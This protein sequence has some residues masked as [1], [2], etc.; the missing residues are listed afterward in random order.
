MS[1]IKQIYYQTRNVYNNDGVFETV[2]AE[3]LDIFKN[4]R[5]LLDARLDKEETYK[6]N[7]LGYKVLDSE[8]EPIR[9]LECNHLIEKDGVVVGSVILR[10]SNNFATHGERM[11]GDIMQR[12]YELRFKTFAGCDFTVES[13]GIAAS[14]RDNGPILINS[15]VGTGFADKILEKHWAEFK[16][17]VTFTAAE[18]DKPTKMRTWTKNQII[19]ARA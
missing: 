2:K 18:V 8:C 13:S 9:S 12:T 5:A 7:G 3:F 16:A 11:F 1:D 10:V 15:C 4:M 19:Y 14:Q 6:A 17:K